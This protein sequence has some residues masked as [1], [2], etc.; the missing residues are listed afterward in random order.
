MENLSF[1]SVPAS[2]KII[3]D[4]KGLL[5]RRRNFLCLKLHINSSKSP[6][7]AW[8]GHDIF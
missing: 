2:H 6:S 3:K 7:G 5:Q 8:V 1:K 4:F